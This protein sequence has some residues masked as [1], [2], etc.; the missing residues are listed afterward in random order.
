MRRLIPILAFL[1]LL[2]S[3]HSQVEGQTV[4][5]R[6]SAPAAA[7]VCGATNATPVVVRTCSPHG[8]NLGDLVGLFGVAT[9]TGVSPVNGV[10][11]VIAS[12]SNDSTHFA[13]GSISGTPIAGTGTYFD[14]S[15]LVPGNSP[16]G[17]SWA[18]KLTAYTLGAQPLG[19]LDG[20]TGPHTRKLSLGTANG[21]TSLTVNNNVATVITSYNHLLNTGD[22]IGIWGS[23]VSALDKVHNPYTVTVTDA[24]TFTFPTS[25]VTNG[26]KT[27]VNNA[28]GPAPTPNDTI[29]GTA[30]CLRI[31]QLAYNGNPAWDGLEI[32]LTITNMN[33]DP[34]YKHVFHGGLVI[35]G[36]Q[37]PGWYANA[38]MKFLVDQSNAQLFKAG[39]YNF[40]N[41][42]FLSSVNW[43]GNELFGSAGNTDTNDYLSHNMNGFAM[44]Y[45]VFAPYA[46]A[47]H[48]TTTLNKLY[49]DVDDPLVAPCSRAHGDVGTNHNKI[50]ASDVA[51][52]GSAT[53]I[54]LSAADTQNDNFYVNNVVLGSF[55][56]FALI[57]GY[58]KSTRTATISG[59]W[60]APPPGQAYTIYATVVVASN[61]A[62]KTTTMTGYNTHFTTDIAVGDAIEGENF[63]DQQPDSSASY[64]SA[65]NSDTSLTVINSWLPG[66]SATV[67]TLVWFFPKWAPGDCGMVQRNKYWVGSFGS[68]PA[69]YP[70]GGSL[71]AATPGGALPTLA[72]DGGNNTAT[73]A[74]SHL[75][76]D[77][78]TAPD[79]ARAIRDLAWTQSF[80]FDYELRHYMNYG[81][82]MHSGS[83][84]TYANTMRGVHQFAEQL[85]ISIP[86]FPSMDLT[87][88]WVMNCSLSK[89]YMTYPDLDAGGNMGA[90]QIQRYGTET[91]NNVSSMASR[92]LTVT[93]VS[94]DPVFTW[95]P[96]SANARYFRNFLET[97]GGYSLWGYQGVADDYQYDNVLHE[98]PRIV[99]SNYTAQ[100]LQYAFQT[101][102]STRC[103]SLTGWP[104]PPLFRGDAVVSRTSW[105]DRAAT[106]MYYGSRTWWGDH[107]DPENGTLRIYKVGELVMTDF[108]PPGGQTAAGSPNQ[109]SMGDMIQFGGVSSTVGGIYTQTAGITPITR[110]ASGNHGTWD[111]AY[112]DQNSTYAYVCSE[113]SGAYLTPMNH[114][115]RCVSHFKKVGA[116]E[117]FVQHDDVDVTGHPIAI[118][119]HVHYTQNGEAA[120][121]GFTYPEGDTICPGVGGCLSLNISRAIQSLEDGGT[122][123]VTARN[124]GVLTNFLSPGTIT[125]RDDAAT[126]TLAVTNV[127]KT[128]TANIASFVTGGGFTTTIVTSTPHGLITNENVR[129]DSVSGT[130]CGGAAGFNSGVFQYA[131]TVI[132]ATHFTIPL[133]S[134]SI[135]SNPSGGTTTSLTLFTAPAHGLSTGNLVKVSGSTGEWAVWNQQ[136]LYPIVLDASHFTEYPASSPSTLLNTTAFNGT[137]TKFYPGGNGHTHRVSI[138]AGSSCGASVNTF[139]SLVIHKI[140]NGLTDTTLTTS[141]LNPDPNWTGVQ[142]CGAVSC[143]VY[144][145]TRHGVLR[146]TIA[147]F[148]TT[149]SGT[150][151]Y[152]FAGLSAGTYAVTINGVGVAGSPFTVSASDNSIE[153]ESTAGTVSFNGSVSVLALGVSPSSLT[154]SCVSGGSNP[155]SQ[156]VAVSATN[157]TLDNWSATKI[158]SWLTLS[159]SSGSAAGNITASV[160]CAGQSAGAFADTITV[161][162]TT[163]GIAN[164]PQTVSVVLTVS[165]PASVITAII[166][167]P[168]PKTQIIH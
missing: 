168:T 5:L 37:A 108:T 9:G 65:I 88:P 162:S 77:L 115:L 54:I 6:D 8:L 50:L 141:A 76:L 29:G 148:T 4:Y 43:I 109:T 124:Y 114:A 127:T 87:G 121:V 39:M 78:A 27:G 164:S 63:W 135:C 89:M 75:V 17:A 79:D 41:P 157:G 64:V 72:T 2:S 140:A 23:G 1:I 103:A 154:Y 59:A 146:S 92:Y 90:I 61:T 142:M 149:H 163:S 31:S 111:T 166:G 144:L 159:P 122:N 158:Q 147:G 21:L 165:A 69:V 48:K 94:L 117:F 84:Y 70:T 132:D 153:F 110:W 136:G 12:S 97:A 11:K 49:N 82:P 53:T 137:I 32:S 102:S 58:V 20:P 24:Q 30:D 38:A 91:D 105:R 93:G 80:G 85:A 34:G 16:G 10:R 118:E 119:T 113:L 95:A 150:A 145:G 66:T 156:T 35:S 96:N 15:N 161:A 42:E 45:S 18:G 167:N 51:Q 139:E 155:A 99:S 13:I 25:G 126:N 128:I 68:Q 7:P 22:K 47:A 28:C 52:G 73:W 101:N 81:C 130:G 60:S 125:L 143:S 104:C 71:T 57:T 55:G 67:P 100:P 46:S 74:A 26:T 3:K 112:G 19:W 56:Q 14:G 98:D 138:C 129:F 123:G 134:R 86:T 160:N 116:D 133:D 40:N 151:Q 62:N 131:V 44:V 83:A 36:F 106:T 107:D 33:N 120:V 152:L